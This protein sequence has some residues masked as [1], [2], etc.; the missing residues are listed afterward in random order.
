MDLGDGASHVL[1]THCYNTRHFDNRYIERVVFVVYYT[2][3]TYDVAY[4]FHS[5]L[6]LA[7]YSLYI[8]FIF[9]LYSLYIHLLIWAWISL[10]S[11]TAWVQKDL[12]FFHPLR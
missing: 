5:M 2:R 8:R 3:H 4:P 1:G 6:Q 10:Y 7:L 11:F 9:A 12:C